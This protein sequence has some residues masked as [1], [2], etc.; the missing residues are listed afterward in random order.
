[1]HDGLIYAAD[2]SGFLHCIDEKTGK[3]YW[4]HDTLAA[5]W[6]SPTVI[7]DKVFL[8]DEDGDIVVLKTGKKMEVVFETNMENSVYTGPVASDGV[9]YL[10]SRT[11]L[12]AIGK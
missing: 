3:P 1:M 4:V 12:Y 2:L 8:G 9:L 11:T 10:A 5:V 6:G 7:G